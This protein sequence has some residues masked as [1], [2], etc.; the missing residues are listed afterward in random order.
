MGYAVVGW[1]C[2]F[3][4]LRFGRGPGRK[5]NFKKREAAVQFQNFGEGSVH[6][7]LQRM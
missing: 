3:A 7:M 1:R 2:A 4:R 5:K 6:A